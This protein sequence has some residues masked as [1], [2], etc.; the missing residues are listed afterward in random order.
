MKMSKEQRDVF[1][2]GLKDEN[3]KTVDCGVIG[4]RGLKINLDWFDNQAAAI[5]GLVLTLA[6][7]SYSDPDAIAALTRSP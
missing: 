3:G 1:F 4:I 7:V 5:L 2:N 6:S